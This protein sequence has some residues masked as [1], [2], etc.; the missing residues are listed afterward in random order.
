MQ[1]Y[2][3]RTS[4]A[5]LQAVG[6]GSCDYEPEGWRIDSFRACHFFTYETVPNT[7]FFCFLLLTSGFE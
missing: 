7:G 1:K 3:D 5:N 4:A 6:M 2:F